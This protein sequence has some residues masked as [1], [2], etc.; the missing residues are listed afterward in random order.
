MKKGVSLVLALT[1][2]ITSVITVKADNLNDAQNNLKNIQNSINDKKEELE[3]INQKHMDTKKSVEQ[4]DEKVNESEKTLKNLNSKITNIDK[5]IK[6]YEKKIE[7]SKKNLE[8]QD[9][10]FKKRVRALYVNGNESYLELIFS[11]NSFS[12]FFSR[13]ESISRVMEYDKKLIESMENNKKA[14]ELQKAELDKTKKENIVLK[15]QADKQYKELQA[16]LTQKQNLMESLEKDKASYEKMIEEEEKESQAIASLI[17]T[18]KKKK[19]EE[20]RKKA[21]EA[22]RKAEEAKKKAE[23]EASRGGSAANTSS[24]N[25]NNTTN[26]NQTIL[27]QSSSSNSAQKLYCVTGRVYPITSP[28]GPRIHPIFGVQ[29]PHTGIDIGVGYGAPIYALKDG[30]VIY[31]GVQGGYGNVVMID[32]GD[33][34]SLYAHNSSLAVSVGQTVKGGQLI[35]RAGSTGNSTGPHLHFEIRKPNGSTI[36]PTPYY[37][38]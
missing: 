31:A 11:S 18:I 16:N 3:N 14:L 34:I 20:A 27:S 32:H 19:E 36:N 12:E 33:I 22:R 4:L 13:I 25:T 8:E 26:T 15:T 24:T 30:E 5:K 23:Q 2:S 38:K 7:E 28:Y 29:K 21:E 9:E 35:S 17:A 37:V 1:L 10:L 6:N